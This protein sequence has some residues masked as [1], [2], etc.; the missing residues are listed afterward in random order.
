[1]NEKEKYRA[2]IEARMAQFNESL[3]DITVK[4]KLRNATPE[5]LKIKSLAE[6]HEQIKAKLNELENSDESTW[7]KIRSELDQLVADVDEDTREALA[8]FG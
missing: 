1:M 8:Y 5:D 7:Q 2:K 4:A 3:E 6:K